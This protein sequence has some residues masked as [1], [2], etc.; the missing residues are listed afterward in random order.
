SQQVADV[1]ENVAT[2]TIIYALGSRVTSDRLTASH[3]PPSSFKAYAIPAQCV[4]SDNALTT[5]YPLMTWTS[6]PNQNTTTVNIAT[7]QSMLL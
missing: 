7:S 3:V 6:E 1:I 2:G 4:K 5:T